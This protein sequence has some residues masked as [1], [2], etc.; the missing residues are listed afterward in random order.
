MV[1][2]IVTAA[3]IRYADFDRRVARCIGFAMKCCIPV[4]KARKR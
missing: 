2:I 1:I 3:V 4:K